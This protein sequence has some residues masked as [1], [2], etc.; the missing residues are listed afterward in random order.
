MKTP[1]HRPRR[2]ALAALGTSLLIA[3]CAVNG[4]TEES[5]GTQDIINGTEV[6]PEGTGH[7]QLPSCSGHL[8]NNEWLLTAK[9]CLPQ[10]TARIGSQQKN[11]V[12]AIPH[13]TLDVAIQRVE[14]PFVVG[15]A[16][17]GYNAR[18]FQG[19]RGDLSGKR[20]Q[21]YGYGANTTNGHGRG[22]LRTA[23]LKATTGGDAS[24][25]EMTIEENSSGQ[26]PF[27]GDS[28]GPCIY[29]D[30]SRLECT[31]GCITG[32]IRG[33]YCY[34]D[35]WT[36]R[37]VNPGDA[38]MQFAG[39]FT[40]WLRNAFATDAL[41]VQT[42]GDPGIWLMQGGARF[43]IPSW[44]E[45]VAIRDTWGYSDYDVRQ[46]DPG[47]L[48]AYPT[49]PRDGSFLRERDSYAIYVIAGGAKFWIPHPGE[50]QALQ[51]VYGY[52][53]SNVQ[54][55]PSGGLAQVGAVPANGT[56]LRERTSAAV[57][58]IIDGGKYWLHDAQELA[59][60]T[61]QHRKTPSHVAVVPPGALAQFPDRS[62][63]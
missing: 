8:L 61:A 55:V 16:T 47:V 13:P 35:P 5:I 3:A 30:G 46:V 17:R 28:G 52:P 14:S 49:S 11:V 54:I 44:E 20:V 39:A 59:Q 40:P 32:V 25:T 22:T 38:I 26:T 43:P 6:D 9:H 48:D 10:S 12:A 62:S 60:L 23:R 37:C 56:F 51:D 57:C 7:V 53:Y 45:Y 63:P 27:D 33:A 29:T 21:C 18:I 41:F 50:L 4:D 15:D 2:G 42:Q 58:L 34:K 36:G 1:W 31:N 19:T 24:P